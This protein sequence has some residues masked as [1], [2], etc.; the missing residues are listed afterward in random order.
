MSADLLASAGAR[1]PLAPVVCWQF[2]I[3]DARP[4]LGDATAGRAPEWGPDGLERFLAEVRIVAVTDESLRL[5]GLPLDRSRV[6]AR[7]IGSLWPEGSHAALTDLLAALAAD[8]GDRIARREI[9]RLDR[10]TDM[11]LTGWRSADPRTPDLVFVSVNATLDEQ[12]ALRELEASQHRYRSLIS[13][14]PL[15]VWQIDA[16]AAGRIFD[17]LRADGVTDF[18]GYAARHPELIQLNY[19]IV[20]VTE[21]NQDAVEL[22]GAA[23]CSQLLGPVSYLFGC[24][25]DTAR[26]VMRAHFDG[27]RNH[28]EQVKIRTFDGRLRDVLLL[29]TFPV[30]GERLDT[31]LVMM[32]DN[33]AALEAEARL[34]QVEADFTH[35]ARLSTL[36]QMTASIAHEIKQ[37]LAAILTNAETSLRWLARADPNLPKVQQLSE[38]IAESAQRASDIIA[39]IHD[40]AGKR[41]PAPVRLDL[42]EV[43]REALSFVRHDSEEKAIR[44]R[45]DMAADLPAVPGDRIQ[46]QQVVVNLLVNSA[47]ALV[48][49]R[50]E[51]REIRLATFQDGTDAVGFSIHDTGPGIPEADLERVFGGFFSTKEGGMGIGLTICRSIVAAHGGTIAASNRPGGGAEFRVSIPVEQPA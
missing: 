12:G 42:N 34:R 25:H 16:R 40:M 35:A 43:I 3:A 13:A 28:V 33:T 10:W 38:R 47:Q 23:E 11:V 5:F 24:A 4:L 17:R 41:R 27:L 20:V 2:D 18:E 6:V 14:L 49:V 21:V 44:L 45:L 48:G 30:P 7:S 29:V 39:R 37:P 46:L 32:I 15:P 22:F 1:H 50:P 26:R 8:D 19:G 51:R 31:T 36:G 9:A